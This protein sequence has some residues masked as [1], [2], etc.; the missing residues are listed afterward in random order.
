[1]ALFIQKFGGT[2]VGDLECIKRVANKVK[3][4]RQAGHDVVVVVSAMGKETDHLLAM[5][6]A[7]SLSP[8]P[9]ECDAL[10]ST[11]EQVSAAM[12][13]LC[14]INMQC[15]ARSYTG[16]QA[17]IYTDQRHGKA[18]IIDIDVGLLRADLQQ[19]IVPVVTGFQGVDREGNI[20]TI[21]RGGSDTTAVMLAAALNAHECQIHTDV[22]GIYTSNPKIVHDARKLSQ[23]TFGEMLELARLGAE[24]LQTSSVRL[25]E[26]HRVP[27]R[28]LSSF[29]NGEGTLVTFEE[30]EVVE[31]I[32][33]GIAFDRNQTKITIRGLPDSSQWL[34]NWLQTVNNAAIEVDMLVKNPPSDQNLI[35]LN[36]TVPFEDHPQALSLSRQFFKLMNREYEI[37]VNERIAKLSV[38]GVGMKT[39]AGAASKIFNV[40]EEEGIKIHLITSSEVTIS[41]I[42]DEKYLEL[43]ARILHSAFELGI[44]KTISY[45]M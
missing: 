20:T 1:M 40:L 15:P 26:Q 19:G 10:L 5:A 39:H 3:Q 13:S 16:T 28:V 14:L 18:R 4:T 35:D 30:N 33:S 31:S 38:V 22:D 23:I 29:I 24:V 9:R 32:V 17:H 42:I 43:G 11:G 8:D 12:M 36:F 27:L 2:S 41:I 6:N 44:E 7:I 25:A 21:G 37:L 34:D 45:S